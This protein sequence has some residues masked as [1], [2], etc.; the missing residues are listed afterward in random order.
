MP[1]HRIAG[2]HVAQAGIRQW[3][4]HGIERVLGCIRYVVGAQVTA[5]AHDDHGL[6]GDLDRFRPSRDG[7]RRGLIDLELG[8]LQCRLVRLDAVV[9]IE[10]PQVAQQVAAIEALRRVVRRVVDPRIDL[11]HAGRIGGCSLARRDVEQSHAGVGVEH[12]E[13]PLSVA[14]VHVVIARRERDDP[15]A[16][17]PLGDDRIAEG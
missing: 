14:R 9:H 15:G 12:E 8:K 6:A 7:L 2:A 13:T 11:R 16:V 17:L 5:R 4:F 1:N 10:A 3:V